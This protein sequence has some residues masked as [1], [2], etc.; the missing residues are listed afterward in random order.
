MLDVV[1]VYAS[2]Y[3]SPYYILCYTKHPFSLLQI[4]DPEIDR[5]DLWRSISGINI[6]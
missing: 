3:N 1:D 6:D 2:A 4:L 5:V